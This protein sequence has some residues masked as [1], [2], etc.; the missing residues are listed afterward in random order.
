MW[1]TT[2]RIR[3][4]FE[5]DAAVQNIYNQCS[6]RLWLS[7]NSEKSVGQGAGKEKHSKSNVHHILK[8]N[9]EK[10]YSEISPCSP[11]RWSGLL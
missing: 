5:A 8:H 6:G 7:T 11:L 1:L 9:L 4:K 2:A 3:D 10:L